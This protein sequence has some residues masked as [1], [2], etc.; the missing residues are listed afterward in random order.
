MSLLFLSDLSSS[1]SAR[2][3]SWRKTS[4]GVHSEL[5]QW[6]IHE[7]INTW[8]QHIAEMAIQLPHWYRS[9]MCYFRHITG[10]EL[11]SHSKPTDYLRLFQDKDDKWFVT[12]DGAGDF[13]SRCSSF[14]DCGFLLFLYD[15][16]L[17]Y[18]LFY[19]LLLFLFIIV[20]YLYLL[21]CFYFFGAYSCYLVYFFII[22]FI[23]IVLL[24]LFAIFIIW[25]YK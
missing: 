5:P 15:M 24:F 8:P 25:Q 10:Q 9:S 2:F 3:R 18:L 22:C 21:Y 20:F 4:V 19:S 13:I 1:T 6:I 7:A 14:M 16:C 23:F 11:W 17:I 12:E